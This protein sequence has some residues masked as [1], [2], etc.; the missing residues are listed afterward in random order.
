MSLP[1]ML[2]HN[3][4]QSAGL[5]NGTGMTI[6]QLG[7]R[8]IEAQII[9]GTRVGD[10]IYIPRIIILKSYKRDRLRVLVD[11][12]MIAKRTMQSRHSL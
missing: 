6:I 4:N 3:L 12:S 8:F 10:K 9:T 1:V 5:C 11:D 7:K 2:M